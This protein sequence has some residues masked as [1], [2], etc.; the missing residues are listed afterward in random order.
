MKLITGI[1]RMLTMFAGAAKIEENNKAIELAFT[2]RPAHRHEDSRLQ[3]DCLNF[4]RF[5][6][7]NHSAT[8]LVPQLAYSLPTPT[9][10]SEVQPAELPR[11]WLHL[12]P[13]RP[14]STAWPFLLSPTFL[15]CSR[16]SSPLF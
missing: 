2:P 12:L 10:T 13:N 6:V 14:S 9:V 7:L 3:F 1:K 15:T 4:H 5:Q 16:S 11:T 8:C